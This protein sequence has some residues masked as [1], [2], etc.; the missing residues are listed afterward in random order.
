[1]AYPL[2]PLLQV[3][4]F[5]ERRAAGEVLAA[6]RRLEEANAQLRAAR[7]ALEDYVIWRAA[8]EERL[9]AEIR[10]KEIA[11]RKLDDH[12]TD[13][14]LIRAREAG[15]RERIQLAE[16][17]CREKAAALTQA[18]D[19]HRASVRE[20]RKIEEHKGIWGREEAFRQALEEDK[21][22]EEFP[23]RKT[24]VNEEG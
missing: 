12:L 20:K 21:E 2:Q 4:A 10:N 5:R 15:F 11:C 8:E 19:A 6:R 1:M 24:V 18:Q 3:R 14:S 16:K 9:F 13:V 23:G 22:L 7:K 17:D